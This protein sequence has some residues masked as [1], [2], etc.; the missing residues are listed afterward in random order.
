MSKKS[1]ESYPAKEEILQYLLMETG[2]RENYPTRSKE[3]MD[4]LKLRLVSFDFGEFGDLNL[5]DGRAILSYDQKVIAVNSRTDE[6]QMNFSKFHEIAHYILPKHRENFFYF[7]REL[8]MT[9]FAKSDLELEANAFAADLIYK[10][11]IFTIE[12]NS[13]EISFE[14][15]IELAERYGSS[16]ESTAWR[17]VECSL[18]PCLFVVYEKNEKWR[19][20]YW[21]FSKP[22]LEKY[23][24]SEKG[25][26]T[27]DNNEDVIKAEL[28][29]GHP[30]ISE[31]D[32]KIMGRGENT[33]IFEYFYNRHNVLAIIKEKK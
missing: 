24:Q 7:C 29:P 17:F 11:D 4:F 32:I 1:I 15:I 6:N 31:C 23:I 33:F 21:V 2:Q 16:I 25:S 28:Q 8:D 12:S 27:D 26:F 22:F 9:R 5:N 14:S 13:V 19:V 20:K 10:G 18:Y 3:I 30:I